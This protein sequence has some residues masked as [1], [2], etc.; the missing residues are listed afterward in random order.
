M[1][2]NKSAIVYYLRSTYFGTVA[3]ADHINDSCLSLRRSDRV[4]HVIR[5]FYLITLL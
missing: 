2:P 1:V 4:L 3:Y 5:L